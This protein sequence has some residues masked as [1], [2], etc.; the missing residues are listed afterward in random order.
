MTGENPSEFTWAGD[1]PVEEVSWYDAVDFAN[2]LSQMEGLEACYEVTE[3]SVGETVV[4]LP[5]GLDR[6]GYRLPTEAE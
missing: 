4:D 2:A 6:L 1:Y 3:N 5:L